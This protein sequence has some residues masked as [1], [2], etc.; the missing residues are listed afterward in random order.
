MLKNVV[1]G[2]RKIHASLETN[3]GEIIRTI[4]PLRIEHSDD[5]LTTTFIDRMENGVEYRLKANANTARQVRRMCFDASSETNQDTAIRVNESKIGDWALSISVI[6]LPKGS[7][8]EPLTREVNQFLDTMERDVEHFVFCGE[9]DTQFLFSYLVELW[10]KSHK[11]DYITA[12][13]CTYEGLAYTWRLTKPSEGKRPPSVANRIVNAQR[14]AQS[15]AEKTKEA[16]NKKVNP[17]KTNK[18]TDAK[19]YEV[20][21]YHGLAIGESCIMQADEFT[22]IVSL[23]HITYSYGRRNGAHYSVKSGDGGAAVVTRTA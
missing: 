18:V 13:V 14:K 19:T 22:S 10:N 6:K 23:R 1:S 5:L 16:F 7:Y 3:L 15:K 21:P 20:K 9:T 17:D 4:G 2:S 8:Y 11:T 12:P